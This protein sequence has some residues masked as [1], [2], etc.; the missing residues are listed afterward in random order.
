MH[1]DATLGREQVPRGCCGLVGTANQSGQVE[2]PSLRTEACPTPSGCGPRSS[3]GAP[4]RARCL[5]VRSH[6][7]LPGAQD[8][9][10]DTCWVSVGPVG[11][12]GGGA[13]LGSP[14]PRGLQTAAVS[15][16]A[17]EALDTR[18]GLRSANRTRPWEAKL[19]GS[20]GP[21]CGRRALLGSGPGIYGRGLRGSTDSATRHI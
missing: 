12:G 11:N 5:R 16:T 1:L 21:R 18:R 15:T 19:R 6:M 9:L 4:R 20:G 10:G 13:D 2:C 7:G 17:G 14:P 8:A 3:P